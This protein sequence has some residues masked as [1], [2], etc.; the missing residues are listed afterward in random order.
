MIPCMQHTP[1][2]GRLTDNYEQLT[3]TRATTELSWSLFAANG[4][5][6]QL[7]GSRKSSEHVGDRKLVRN[8][9]WKVQLILHKMNESVVTV[10]SL[11]KVMTRKYCWKERE[12]GTS[13]QPN[14]GQL[15]P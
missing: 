10:L 7:P 1:T 2:E 4:E 9:V 3:G 14:P 11:M 6:I 8:T 12:I 15:T 13:W 5:G